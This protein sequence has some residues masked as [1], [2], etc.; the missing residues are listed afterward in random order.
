[1]FTNCKT[2]ANWLVLAGFVA[3]TFALPDVAVAAAP[4]NQLQKIDNELNQFLAGFE[5]TPSSQTPP[6]RRT[7]CW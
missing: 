1:M 7:D 5:K 6:Q 3:G 4:A 2:R